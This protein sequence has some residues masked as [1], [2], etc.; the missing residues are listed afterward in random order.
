MLRCFNV[1]VAAVTLLLCLQDIRAA[2][3]LLSSAP[4]VNLELWSQLARAAGQQGHWQLARECAT[5]AL[6]A[7]PA[8]KRDLQAVCAAADVPEVSPQGWYWLAV[9]EM[10]HGQVRRGTARLATDARCYTSL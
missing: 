3:S 10:Q 8:G 6:G 5:A 7:L 4:A 9:A 1:P 2:M